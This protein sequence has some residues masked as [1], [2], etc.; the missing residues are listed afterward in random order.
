MKTDELLKKINLVV[1]CLMNMG[2][3]DY[4]EDKELTEEEAKRTGKCNRDFGIEEWDWPQGVG[5]YGL[6]KLQ[7]HY[8][9]DRYID[10]FRN[11]YESNLQ[12]GLPSKNI[13]TTAPYLTLFSLLGKLPDETGQYEAMCKEQ[14]DWLVYELP[15]TEEGGFQHVTSAIGNRNGVILNESELWI[16]TLFMAVLFLNKMGIRYNNNEWLGES[17]HQVLLHIKYLY[18]KK[19]RLFYHGWSFNRNDNFG[20]IYWCR[21]NSWFTLGITDFLADS[22]DILD[23]GVCTFLTDTFR[24]QAEKLRTLQSPSGLWPTVLTDPNSYDE[25]SGS[26]AIAAGLIK[27]IKTGLLDDSYRSCA[28]KAIQAVMDNVAEDGTVQNVSA[29]TAMGYNADHYKNIMIHPMAYGQS[30]A[31]IALCEALD[32]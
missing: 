22:L 27:G 28:E 7:D 2:G 18:E 12:I 1:D 6:L 21:G 11:W 25:V 10:F 30:L 26:A 15:K 19:D 29:G 17:V 23:P 31:L 5:L 32:F 3:A 16:D 24:A 14:A 8:K 20:G 9:D 13:N 4:D